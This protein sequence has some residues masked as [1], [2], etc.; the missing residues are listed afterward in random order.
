MSITE[1]R[2][3][4]YPKTL[5]LEYARMKD[6]PAIKTSGG[7]KYLFD[8]EKLESIRLTKSR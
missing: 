4:G 6:S 8:T 3:L 1:L 2:E 7:G 5:L